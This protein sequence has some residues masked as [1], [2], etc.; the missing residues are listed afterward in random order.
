MKEYNQTFSETNRRTT[1]QENL[2]T[3]AKDAELQ[4]RPIV[5]SSQLQYHKRDNNLAIRS[6]QE[7]QALVVLRKFDSNFLEEYE[8]CPLAFQLGFIPA[9]P[10]DKFD[11]VTAMITDVGFLASSQN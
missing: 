7:V 1:L 5:A 4:E 6:R 9:I 8:R 2:T 10:D 3:A 11:I